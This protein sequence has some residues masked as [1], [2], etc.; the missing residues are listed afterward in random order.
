MEADA[1]VQ[2]EHIQ[3][4]LAFVS[5]KKCARRQHCSTENNVT[6]PDCFTKTASSQY[7]FYKDSAP[8]NAVRTRCYEKFQILWR[9]RRPPHLPQTL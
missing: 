8:V 9:T 7:R 1:G 6:G 2:V 5:M 4:S 3:M